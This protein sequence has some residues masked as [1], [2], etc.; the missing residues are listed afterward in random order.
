MRILKENARE[1]RIRLMPETGDDLWE[2]SHIIGEGD[3][4]KA[5]TE[6][7]VKVGADKNKVERK[8]M[9]L[10][11]TVTAVNLE[12][13]VLRVQGTIEEGPD[14]LISYGD[15]HSIQI[16]EHKAFELTKEW[17][18]VSRAKLEQAIKED[19]NHL[20]LVT[21]DRDEAYF[22]KLSKRGH[23]QLAHLKGDVAKKRMGGG[24]ENFW[25]TVSH[26]IS[27]H[28]TRSDYQHIILAAPAF[29]TDYVTRELPDNIRKKAI[30]AQCSSIGPQ[31]LQEILTREEVRNAV[32]AD[33]NAQEQALLE[34]VLQAV[35]QD[36]AAYGIDEVEEKARLGQLKLVVVTEDFIRQAREDETF[37]RVD[38]VLSTV[39]QMKGDV[40]LLEHATKQLDALGGIAGITRW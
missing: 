2:L 16:E 20:L 6:R 9:T 31:A 8:P 13:H 39:K 17:D 24:S 27:E 25:E 38:E 35:H 11:I 32:K 40:H 7:K 37:E 34:D 5:R 21:F 12:G 33:R 15:H 26:Q 1:G 10:T 22:F 18:Q 29:W 30:I 3:R 28:N 23:K 4:V 36:Q 19:A 14:D